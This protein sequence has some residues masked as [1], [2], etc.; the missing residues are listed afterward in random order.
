M[1]ASELSRNWAE[2]WESPRG[3][4]ITEAYRQHDGFKSVCYITN[5][6]IQW[7]FEQ[8]MKEKT[9]EIG[10]GFIC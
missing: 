8:F 9:A 7:E 6:E 3:L 2:F 1:T 4:N 5:T 10:N